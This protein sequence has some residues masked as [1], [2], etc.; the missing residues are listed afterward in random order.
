MSKPQKEWIPPLKGWIKIN[1]NGTSKENLGKART[2]G[3]SQRD[4]HGNF[5]LQ[6]NYRS[7]I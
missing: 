2:R 7:G 5:I 1:F 3:N 4:V 6:S